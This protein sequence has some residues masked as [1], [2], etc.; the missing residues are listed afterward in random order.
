MAPPQI[1][2]G[3]S[4][5][6]TATTTNDQTPANAAP[7][8]AKTNP[9]T[10]MGGTLV[11]QAASGYA[12]AQVTLA[13]GSLAQSEAAGIIAATTNQGK[14]G[15]GGGGGGGSDASV[16]AALAALQAQMDDL[17]AQNK[18]NTQKANESALAQI[19]TTLTNYGFSADQVASLSAFAWGEIQNNIDPTQAA[20]DLQSQ[21]AFIAKFPAIRERV[22]A[23]LPPITPAE[24]LSTLD[25]YTQTLNAAGISPSS[26]DLNNLVAKDVSP[27]ELSDR[28][29]QGYLAVAQAP[30]DVISAM[31]N[32]YGVTKGQ[33]VQY[34][35]DPTKHEATL[36][37]QAAAA[38]IG[39][40]AT[41]SGFMG[42]NA[43]STTPAISQELALQL[44]QQGVT[45]QQAQSGFAT[46]ANQAQLYNP[47]PGQGQVRG[48][49]GAP[50]TA[51]QLAEAQFFGGPAE[52]AL[53]LQAQQEQ[54]YFK[55]GTSVGTSGSQTAVGQLQ[56]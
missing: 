10:T 53:Q 34:F 50:Y 52:Q 9:L 29:Q 42:K 40:A 41:G 18:A 56:R 5:A 21:P 54:A 22:T 36:L 25:S 55:Q 8:A 3:S 16:A 20:L 26:L 31:Q 2:P 11:S 49:G 47:L 4:T 28:V 15:G 1:M 51:N 23:G 14:G 19:K 6:T 45:Y 46:L 48:N 37:Q 44:A 38:Q 13:G 33:L 12:P 39:G 35:T 24:Y 30:Q 32:Y 43:Q 7:V 27:T 17:I